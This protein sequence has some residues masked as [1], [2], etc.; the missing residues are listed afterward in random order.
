MVSFCNKCDN[1]LSQK[2]ETGTLLLKCDNCGTVKQPTPSDMII[3]DN[4]M[5]NNKD[6]GFEYF[7]VNAAYKKT[8]RKV[9]KTCPKCK[10]KVLTFIFNESNQKS[11]YL[12]TCS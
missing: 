1:F 10:T 4:T 11:I 3:L 7:T 9:K 6:L 12:C 5:S 2:F 8:N